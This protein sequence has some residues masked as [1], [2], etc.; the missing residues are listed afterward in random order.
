M[1]TA[2]IRNTVSQE[3]TDKLGG[4]P[5][6]RGDSRTAT[7]KG[8]EVAYKDGTT[9]LG[10]QTYY[11]RSRS[12]TDT[13]TTILAAIMANATDLGTPNIT[14]T[15][16][17]ITTALALTPATPPSDLPIVADPVTLSANTSI[18]TRYNNIFVDTASGD[19]TM[20]LLDP[21]TCLGKSLFF[22]NIGS[23]GHKVTVSGTLD[24]GTSYE[25]NTQGSMVTYMSDGTIWRN[26]GGV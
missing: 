20:T 21:T 26:V 25:L 18:D 4:D 19:L 2:T 7:Y 1:V 16:S 24:V 5:V 17:D 23:T 12:A 6:I 9:E 8:I 22:Q 13:A 15:T 10:S 14:I 11:L 3:I